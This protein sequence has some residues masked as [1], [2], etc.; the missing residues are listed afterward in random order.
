M[1]IVSGKYK[2]RRWEVPR[3][4]KARPTTDFAKENLFN[5]LA[6][7]LDLEECSALDLFSGTGSIAFEMLSRG[8]QP[9]VCVEKDPAHAAFI[10]KVLADLNDP[11]LTV[12]RSDV[13]QYLDWTTQKFHLI[14]A[15][16]P[17][18]MD[19]LAEIPQRILDRNMV[20]PD[21]WLVMEHPKEYDFSRLPHFDQVRKYGAVHFSLFHF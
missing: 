10:R 3:T 2:S 14:F 9:V 1:R 17:Y 13:F 7:R 15:D 18:A 11:N 12:I 4:F 6:N 8:C 19:N 16:P 21:G 20:E 5:V